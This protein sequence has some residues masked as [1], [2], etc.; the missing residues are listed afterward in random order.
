MLRESFS[1]GST[2][3]RHCFGIVLS[4]TLSNSGNIELIMMVFM[5]SV[6]VVGLLFVGGAPLCF[7]RVDQKLGRESGLLSVMPSTWKLGV[8]FFPER[9]HETNNWIPNFQFLSENSGEVF[10]HHVPQIICWYFTEVHFSLQFGYLRYLG[11]QTPKKHAD[12]RPIQ[13]HFEEGIWS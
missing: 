11:H 5:N 9:Q 13:H 4:A 10:F 3:F 7:S 1:A 12:W 2:S 6:L 8:V